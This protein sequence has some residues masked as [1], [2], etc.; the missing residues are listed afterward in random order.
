MLVVN[1]FLNSILSERSPSI[2][3]VRDE[4]MLL[5]ESFAENPEQFVSMLFGDHTHRLSADAELVIA[6][7]ADRGQFLNA[8]S[9]TGY[10]SRE[11]LASDHK[12]KEM[13]MIIEQKARVL[14]EQRYA[15]EEVRFSNMETNEP[16]NFIMSYPRS[17]NNYLTSVLEKVFPRSR[18]S[19][20]WGDGHYFSN[21]SPFTRFSTPFFVKDHAVK[22]EYFNNPSLII[23]RPFEEVIYSVAD[24][25]MRE[26]KNINILKSFEDMNEF[27]FNSY[28]FGHWCDFVKKVIEYKKRGAPFYVLEYSE[29]IGQNGSQEI[30]QGLEFLGLDA[31][32]DRL[33]FAIE[34]ST[35]A[36]KR[37][38][39]T[40]A[41]WSRE[42][43]Y[44]GGH[45]MKSWL[46]SKTNKT[47]FEI[48]SEHVKLFLKL[49]VR[50]LYDEAVAR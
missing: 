19:V 48:P 38:R 18:H 9:Y 47:S 11:R 29:I 3:P 23:I 22:R 39:E 5:L 49:N 20:F 21:N 36:E 10:I 26:N 2:D 30:L 45:F 37:L 12:L 34:K 17:G 50:D 42:N 16:V 43:I 35:T 32:I 24:Y 15:G 4:K 44:E 41:V 27:F 33:D 25:V 8:L 40:E 28:W 31:D 46:D 6:M 7:L 1:M 13:I 14:V